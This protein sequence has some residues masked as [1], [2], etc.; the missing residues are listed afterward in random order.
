M[1]AIVNFKLYDRP[2]GQ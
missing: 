1:K 2:R